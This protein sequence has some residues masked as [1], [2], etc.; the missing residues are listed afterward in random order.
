[1]RLFVT[2]LGQDEDISLLPKQ[3]HL[4]LKPVDVRFNGSLNFHQ[5]WKFDH[6]KI[7]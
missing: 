3:S 5:I 7:D 4:L 2:Y 1:M 6:L